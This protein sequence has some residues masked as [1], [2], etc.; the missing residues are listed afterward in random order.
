MTTIIRAPFYEDDDKYRCCS[1]CCHVTVGV[2]VK[3]IQ[4]FLQ[5]GA[6]II[7]GFGIFFTVISMLPILTIWKGLDAPAFILV[8][9]LPNTIY[10]LTFVGVVYGV[11]NRKTWSFWP[12]LILYVSIH[13]LPKTQFAGYPCW[14][15]LSI[16]P[17]ASHWC[18]FSGKHYNQCPSS[19]GS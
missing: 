4:F 11:R 16:H 7:A 3:K 10:L 12:F 1:N 5:T 9:I 17:C 8:L 2:F 13:P 18:S 6:N 14:N 15:L 19:I